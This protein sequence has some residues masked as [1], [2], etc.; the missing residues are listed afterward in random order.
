MIK[1]VMYQLVKEDGSFDIR[2]CAWNKKTGK[3][4][5]KNLSERGHV[6]KRS[7][8]IGDW[9]LSEQDYEHIKSHSILN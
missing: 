7:I 6:F 4:L 5:G 3:P 8:D 1:I 9:T 2:G